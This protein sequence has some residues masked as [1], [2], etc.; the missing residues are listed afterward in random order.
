MTSINPNDQ[1]GHGDPVSLLSNHT[2]NAHGEEFFVKKSQVWLNQLQS[3]AI[4]D[5]R[6]L[7]EREVAQLLGVS[8]K[9]VARHNLRPVYLGRCKRYRFSDVV[10]ALRGGSL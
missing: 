9:T 6:F 2:T 3:H 10:S 1:T 4:A 8:P 7:S 5:E